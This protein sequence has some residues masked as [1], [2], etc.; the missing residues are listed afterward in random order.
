[1]N[2]DEDSRGMQREREVLG[3]K[4]HLGSTLGEI[5]CSTPG[6]TLRG[7]RHRCGMGDTRGKMDGE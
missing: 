6:L 5:V 4:L 1:V 7:L 2:L 3:D